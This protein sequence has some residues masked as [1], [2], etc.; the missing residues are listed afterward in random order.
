MSSVAS[1][2]PSVVLGDGAPRNNR[3][4]TATENES[5][6]ATAVV[7][8][9][10]SAET[11]T[12]AADSAGATTSASSSSASGLVLAVSGLQGT[13]NIVAAVGYVAVLIL[14]N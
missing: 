8:K 12:A 9:N 1:A 10:P 5:K 7:T 11:S 6:T 14:V 13:I 4:T 3:S 2:T